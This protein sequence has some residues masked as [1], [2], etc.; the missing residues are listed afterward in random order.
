[1]EINMIFRL[2]VKVW[3]QNRRMKWRHSKQE[4]KTD[5]NRTVKTEIKNDDDEEEED[6]NIPVASSA[7]SDSF[8]S[9]DENEIDIEAE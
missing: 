6:A 5:K 1:M 4:S 9:E 7:E 8:S 2:K 3:F